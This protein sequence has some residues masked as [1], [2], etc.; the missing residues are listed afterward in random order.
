MN[1]LLSALPIWA[2]DLSGGLTVL[3]S[4]Y[5][6]FAKAT[7]TGTGATPLRER[8]AGPAELSGD[9]PRAT[10]AGAR[11]GQLGEGRPFPVLRH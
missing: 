7:P 11:G 8:G 6:L 2:L 10:G 1:Q 4:L 5:F 9:R 3:V